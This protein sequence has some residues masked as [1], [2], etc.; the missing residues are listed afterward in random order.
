MSIYQAWMNGQLD[1]A[2]KLGIVRISIIEYLRL[3]HEYLKERTIGHN[4]T[5]A[6]RITA[7][8]LG[9]SEITIKRAIAI[10]G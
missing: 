2:L 10:V 1:L 8:R 5:N 4:Y 3:Y 9:A 7:E 6:V